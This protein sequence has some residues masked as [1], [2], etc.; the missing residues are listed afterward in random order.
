MIECNQAAPKIFIP[1]RGKMKVQKEHVNRCV[2]YDW[3]K[4]GE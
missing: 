2:I 1:M 3:A 4:L